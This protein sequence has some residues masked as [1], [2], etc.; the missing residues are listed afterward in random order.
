[1]IPA[2]HRSKHPPK[3]FFS[4]GFAE[5]K[6]QLGE[7][8]G[9]PIEMEHPPPDGG[10]DTIQL[11]TNGLAAW[12]HGE[13]PAFTDGDQTW[14]L[15]LPGIPPQATSAASSSASGRS[16]PLA[17]CIIRAESG[18]NPSAVNPRSGAS[19]LG[20]FLRSTW[21]STPQGRA[22]YSVFDPV[23]NRE[24]VNWMLNVGRAREFDTL[25]GCR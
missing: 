19:G 17:E 4:Q 21:L 10:A 2:D 5:L 13:L 6:D 8:M 7:L 16:S 23:A 24:A 22:G 9:D 20:Q 12:T 1:M 15:K 14:R 11:T 18:G 25:R 3:P